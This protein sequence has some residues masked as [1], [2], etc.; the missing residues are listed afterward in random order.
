M[1][2]GAVVAGGTGGR[3]GLVVAAG[4]AGSTGYRGMRSGER[5]SCGRVVDGSCP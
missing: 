4:M 5:I 2:A 1:V 3:H